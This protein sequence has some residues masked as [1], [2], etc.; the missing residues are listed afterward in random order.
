M[1]YP[2]ST[3]FPGLLTFPG[4]W[5]LT[6]PPPGIVPV[7]V[8]KR[9]QVSVSVAPRGSV[10]PRVPWRPHVDV[11]IAVPVQIAVTAF[12]QMRAEVAVP[13]N[14]RVDY[15]ADATGGSVA[16]TVPV[17]VSADVSV[18]QVPF[19]APV[20]SMPV[21]AQVY[22]TK[23][24]AKFR[25]S[26][27]TKSGNFTLSSTNTWVTI[28]SWSVRSGFPDTEI[29]SNGVR[30]PDQA[31]ITISGQLTYG[32]TDSASGGGLQ[33]RVMAGATQIGATAATPGGGA[34]AALTP[35]T[36]KNETGTDVIVTVQGRT[37]STLGSREIIQ[38]GT[39]SWLELRPVVPLVM[40]AEDDFDRPNGALGSNWT[41]TGGGTLKIVNGRIDGAG[42]PSVPISHAWWHQPMPSDTQVVRGVVRWD[43][44]NPEHSATGL[45]VRGNPTGT[46]TAPG[47][48]YGV[49]FSWTR[50]IMSLYY[51]DHNATNGFTPVT[52]TAQYVTTTKFPEG[53]VV[54]LRAE[55]NLYTA[56]VNGV[57][58]LQGTVP[59]SVIPFTNRYV[60][61]T[62]QDDSAVQNGGGPPGRLD[63]FEALTPEE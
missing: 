61:V 43:G 8:A 56:S 10:P 47:R 59:S 9:P 60:G 35:F 27:L 16:L 24:P 51:E 11:D 46:P 13:L 23:L 25:A 36:W 32:S 3:T 28:P 50:G 17:S 14:L 55:G 20:V 22:A 30:V 42:T 12:P 40:R 57:V 48:Q 63:D 33:M 6:W 34:V 58:Q 37:N 41:T 18:A 52:G 49:Q 53:A 44:M 5:E 7:S 4:T 21:D 39:G 19:F 45:I 62:I 15:V 29:V 2:G 38:G 54:E 31:E 26:G 1:T